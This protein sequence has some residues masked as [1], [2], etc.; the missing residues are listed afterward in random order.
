MVGKRVKKI[1]QGPPPPLFGQSP[2]EIDFFMG[3]VLLGTRIWIH[4]NRG[5][6]KDLKSEKFKA[7][8]F[9]LAII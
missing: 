1:G 2:Q 5:G 6:L 8:I 9:L 7:D 3:D 4:D